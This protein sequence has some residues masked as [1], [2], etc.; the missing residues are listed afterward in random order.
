M[1]KTVKFGRRSIVVCTKPHTYRESRV[2]L[3]TTRGAG[4]T[5]RALFVGHRFTAV[6]ITR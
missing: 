1:T 5:M 3:M 4:V 6:L 2:K